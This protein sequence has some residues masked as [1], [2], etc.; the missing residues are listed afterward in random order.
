LLVPKNSFAEFSEKLIAAAKIFEGRPCGW[1]AF[2]IA[3]IENGIPRFGADMDETNLPLECGIENRAMS[4]NKG[5]YIGQEILNRVHSFGHVNKEL[6]GLRLADDLKTLP[7][8]H[9]KLF[10][11]AKEIGYV[12]S[13]VKS[14]SLNANIALGYVRREASQIGNELALQ[15]A[16][17]SPAKIVK[18]PFAIPC[19]VR[20]RAKPAWF[21]EHLQ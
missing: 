4:F 17:E 21:N 9:D 10:F 18:L 3:R 15:G 13:A 6:R 8:K 2:E 7:Q 11:G 12:T 5:C 20:N 1:T 14:P 16:G 19:E